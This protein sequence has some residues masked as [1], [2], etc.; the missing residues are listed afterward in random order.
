MGVSGRKP[1]DDNNAQKHIEDVKKGNKKIF[2]S[3]FLALGM[4]SAMGK[5]TWHLQA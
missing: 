5:I 1:Q 4:L 3:F 2:F